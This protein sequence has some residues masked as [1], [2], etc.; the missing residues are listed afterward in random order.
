MNPVSHGQGVA[1]L[2][3]DNKMNKY[4]DDRNHLINPST[5]NQSTEAN[6]MRSVI[7]SANHKISQAA[8]YRIIQLHAK[9]P[10]PLTSN[11]LIK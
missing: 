1:N 10:M 2:V 9:K 4:I 8:S 6:E 11:H 7:R 3:E 5:I